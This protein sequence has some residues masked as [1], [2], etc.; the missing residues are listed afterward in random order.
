MWKN[1]LLGKHLII[2]LYEC[3][4][5]RLNSTE[6]VCKTLSSAVRL[7]GGTE[8]STSSKGFTPQ[9]VTAVMLLE[10]SHCSIHTWPEYGY[11]AIDYFTCSAAVNLELACNLMMQ[12]FAAKTVQVL[13]VDRGSFH[14]NSSDARNALIR[15]K[16][17]NWVGMGLDLVK[18]E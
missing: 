13:S 11:A 9:G 15:S 5:D 16:S 8:I 10:E 14:L 12:E 1:N 18:G 4:A 6:F 3:E 17:S 2:E 7:S